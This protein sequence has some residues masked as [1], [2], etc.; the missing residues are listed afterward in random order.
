MLGPST[1]RIGWLTADNQWD[2]AKIKNAHDGAT[3]YPQVLMNIPGWPSAW[4][5]AEGRLLPARYTDYAN[6]CTDLL[7]IINVDQG[8]GIKT[9]KSPTNATTC[10][11]KTP[12]NWAASSPR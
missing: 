1:S 5:D 12:T 9:G 6:W 3:A 7:R 4:Q 8:R 2:A 11:R 10:T